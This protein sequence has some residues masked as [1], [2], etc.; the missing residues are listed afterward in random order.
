MIVICMGPD[1]VCVGGRKYNRGDNGGQ[2]FYFLNE[3]EESGSRGLGDIPIEGWSYDVTCDGKW[4]TNIGVGIDVVSAL[5]WIRPAGIEVVARRLL[6]EL[7]DEKVKSCK[8]AKKFRKIR[9]D[10]A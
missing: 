4:V 7:S 2:E 8:L 9:F 5:G 6:K 3:A 1:E 10:V